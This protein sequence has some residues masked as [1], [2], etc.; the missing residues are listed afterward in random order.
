MK[1]PR[2]PDR[3]GANLNREHED[4]RRHEDNDISANDITSHDIP[5]RWMNFTRQAVWAVPGPGAAPARGGGRDRG[6]P[7]VRGTRSGGGEG[8]GVFSLLSGFLIFY[9]IDIVYIYIHSMYICL[10]VRIVDRWC[11]LA[12]WGV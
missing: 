9:R 12:R 1:G 11:S 4:M 8:C 3:R 7:A 2:T 10:I 6:W 5:F